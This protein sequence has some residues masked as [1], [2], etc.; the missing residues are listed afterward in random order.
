MSDPWLKIIFDGTAPGTAKVLRRVGSKRTIRKAGRW[1]VFDKEFG[2]RADGGPANI[3]FAAET[4]EECHA[5]IDAQA[6]AEPPHSHNCI[7]ADCSG[8]ELTAEN[9]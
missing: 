7:C 4:V 5:Y 6:E 8:A 3:L 1:V 2:Y 9:D